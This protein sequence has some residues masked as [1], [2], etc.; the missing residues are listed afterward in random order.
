M[1]TSLGAADGGVAL[2][3]GTG[4]L[5]IPLD[6]RDVGTAHV[7]DVLLLGA[8][9]LNGEGD[10]FEAH[11]G[12]ITGAGGAHPVSHHFGLFDDLFDGELANDPAEMTFHDEADESF[13]VVTALGEELL[14]CG[15]DRFR[16]ALNFDLGDRF[17]SVGDALAGLDI[18]SGGN[19]KTHEFEGEFPGGLKHG[20]DNRAPTF[21]NAGTAEAADNQGLVWSRFAEQP[22]EYADEHKHRQR[23]QRDNYN[24]LDRIQL[25]VLLR[26]FLA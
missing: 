22:R 6:A 25:C 26:L 15:D 3:F 11:L 10:D 8:N 1:A 4:N 20:E 5:G 14:G 19:V 23:H 16:V 24:N 9:F 13:T 18:L 21:D 7:G 2:G 17:H 12:H